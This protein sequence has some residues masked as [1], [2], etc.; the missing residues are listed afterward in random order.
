[1][2]SSRSQSSG[3]ESQFYDFQVNS[4]DFE[5]ARDAA[6]VSDHIMLRDTEDGL[7][8]FV[9]GEA[10][11]PRT[12]HAPAKALASGH[13]IDPSFDFPLPSSVSTT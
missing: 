12:S 1:L 7:R 10:A 13:T 3:R 6:R 11:Q 9:K 4:P 2:R 8:Y 5:K